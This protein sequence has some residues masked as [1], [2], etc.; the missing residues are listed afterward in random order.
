MTE[1]HNW[2]ELSEL[3]PVKGWELWVKVESECAFLSLE[4]DSRKH[5]YF[6]TRTFHNKENSL[7]VEKR[8]KQAGYDV[9]II[10]DN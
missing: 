10:C 4:S 9:R 1:I 5:Y 2:K 6:T 8:L 3:E 7:K